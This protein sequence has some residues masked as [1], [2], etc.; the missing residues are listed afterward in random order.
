MWNYLSDISI[1]NVEILRFLNFAATGIGNPIPVAAPFRQRSVLRT[2]P[3]APSTS[4]SRVSSP[5]ST[6]TS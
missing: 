6:V 3:V 5:T 2:S 1:S 4:T